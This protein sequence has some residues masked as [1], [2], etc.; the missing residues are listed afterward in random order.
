MS[1]NVVCNE[2]KEGRNLMRVE[3]IRINQR[4]DNLFD[5]KLKSSN[6][7][8]DTF[9]IFND[10]NRTNGIIRN[11]IEATIYVQGRKAYN[12]EDIIGKQVIVHLENTI[13]KKGN[14]FLKIK[15]FER[16]TEDT[17]LDEFK[18]QEETELS[19]YTIPKVDEVNDLSDIE[20]L[21]E[22]E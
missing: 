19:I 6:G 15:K 20:D 4:F 17:N 10:V 16:V 8:E 9:G 7:V 5:I 12:L 21:L 13:S 1:L 14:E 11:L 18:F 22:V 2:L 3:T